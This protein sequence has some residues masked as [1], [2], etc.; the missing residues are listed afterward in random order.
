MTFKPHR[1]NCCAARAQ[2]GGS[3]TRDIRFRRTGALVTAMVAFGLL[4]AAC[5][6]GSAG[7]GVAS[8]GKTTTTVSSAAQSA[9]TAA[10]YRDAVAY[11]Q[12]MR[13]HGVPNMPDPTSS[14]AFLSK[15]GTLNGV[16]GVDPNSPQFASANKTC[17]HL[18]PNGGNITPAEQQKA[19]A[20]ALK[21]V[22]CMRTH[23]VPNMP[24]PSTSGGGVGLILG[25]GVSPSSPQFQSAQQACRSFQPLGGA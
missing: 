11:A 8:L 3:P 9:S 21:Y 24:D 5:G 13:T 12:C 19:L 10:N 1:Q 6:G 2:A 17:E 20:Q 23:G 4:T 15:R 14:G 16:S 22:H 18:L 25:P 7:P